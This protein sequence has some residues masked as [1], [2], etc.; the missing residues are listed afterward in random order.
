MRKYEKFYTATGSY[1][2]DTLARALLDRVVTTSNVSNPR[3]SLEDFQYIVKIANRINMLD[4]FDNRLDDYDF[5]D[6][7]FP[8]CLEFLIWP[9]KVSMVSSY[10]AK[11]LLPEYVTVCDDTS[12]YSPKKMISAIERIYSTQK[13]NGEKTSVQELRLNKLLND[14]EW[15]SFIHGESVMPVKEE[16]LNWLIPVKDIVVDVFGEDYFID[17]VDYILNQFI[18]RWSVKPRTNSR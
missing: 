2:V 15:F 17:E 3:A 10:R 13:E 9:S 6:V 5:K 12:I 7:Y 11:D 8:K 14:V 4:E 16:S 1:D 18:I